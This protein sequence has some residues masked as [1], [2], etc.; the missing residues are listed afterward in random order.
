VIAALIG[1]SL[2]RIGKPHEARGWID[3][4]LAATPAEGQADLLLAAGDAARFDYDYP[5]A[6]AL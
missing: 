1:R 6:V 2:T 3:R 5:G 4:A